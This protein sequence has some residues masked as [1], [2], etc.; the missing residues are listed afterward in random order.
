ML[1]I[2][3]FFEACLHSGP[4]TNLFKSNF[5][6]LRLYFRNHCKQHRIYMYMH[7][8]HAC[9]H[10]TV[11]Y[12]NNVLLILLGGVRGSIHNQ[13][14]THLFTSILILFIGNDNRFGEIAKLF[15]PCGLIWVFSN[16]TSY[17]YEAV[18]KIKPFTKPNGE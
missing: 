14:L 8:I 16:D 1:R 9:A 15:T 5:S 10:N 17:N 18:V 6:L 7:T 4:E 12:L 13:Q 11:I 3:T 2:F